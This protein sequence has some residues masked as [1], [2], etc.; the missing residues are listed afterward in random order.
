MGSKENK[1]SNEELNIMEDVKKSSKVKSRVKKNE[2]LYKKISTL[3]IEDF[4]VNSNVSI[5][6]ESKNNIDIS[7][8][9]AKLKAKY[10]EEPRNKSF[11][12][13]DEIDLPPI[14]LDETREYDINAIIER[15]KK[16]QEINYE[17][18]R[19]KKISSQEEIIK[20]IE[21]LN[22]KL[23]EKSKGNIIKYNSEEE[24]QELIDTIN[25]KELIEQEATLEVEGELDPLDM[26]SDL[27]GDDDNTK[28]MG[29]LIDPEE[30]TT[31]EIEIVTDDDKPLTEED[32]V[33]VIE[34]TGDVDLDNTEEVLK[35]IEKQEKKK[36]KENKK[37]ARRLAK[38]A[39][40]KEKLVKKEEK[41]KIANLDN[42]F[43]GNT[44]IINKEDYDDFADLKED[45]KVTKIVIKILI[46]LI[47][48]I[49]IAGV[50]IFLNSKFNWG[51]F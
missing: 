28:V 4:D 37:E 30:L 20:D 26:F 17:E 35:A 13:T 3:D 8:I 12:N 50:V 42:S 22:E 2:N 14:N 7:D 9:E 6:G 24:I 25:A 38:E 27:K 39:K 15:A 33:E 45:M 41:E 44:T 49:F 36:E 48:L 19:L 46:F 43:I 47:I 32:G 10:K 29:Q 31:S 34:L 23:K 11:G 40:R 1:S 16:D 21:N 18:D 51:L 5:L